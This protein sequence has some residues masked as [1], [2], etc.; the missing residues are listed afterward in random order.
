MESLQQRLNTLAGT[1]NLSVFQAA[2]VLAGTNGQ[3]IQSALNTYAGTKNLSIQAALNY[4]AGTV[5]KSV[6]EAANAIST[7]YTLFDSYGTENIS[8]VSSLGAEYLAGNKFPGLSMVLNGQVASLKR[9]AMH[10]KRV[11]TLAGN[12]T[13]TLHAS[14]D[15]GG[16][17][18]VPDG[19][20]LATAT[21]AAS[22]ISTTAGLVNFDFG[23]PYTMADLDY[24]IA[25][26]YSG[27]DNTQYIEVSKDALDVSPSIGGYL[28]SSTWLGTEDTNYIFYA[29]K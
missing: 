19:V 6:T 26:N 18:L 21:V 5:S 8:G 1:N 3:S 17:Y 24:C 16:G 12:V 27:G 4:K 13:I 20:A 9:V 15:D 14:V 25:I 7:G 10:L 28:S 22:S 2:N 11:G 23:T 29:Y